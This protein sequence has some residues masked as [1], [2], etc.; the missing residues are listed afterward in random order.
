ME[1][2]KEQDKLHH[3]ALWEAEW[4]IWHV[5]KTANGGRWRALSLVP[6]TPLTFRTA[7]APVAHT[8][9]PCINHQVIWP[10]GDCSIKTSGQGAIHSKS[11]CTH[12]RA[13]QI[14]RSQILVRQIFSRLL[15]YHYKLTKICQKKKNQ[16]PLLKSFKWQ[17][18]QQSAPVI[19]ACSQIDDFIAS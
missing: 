12:K 3:G 11:M 5:I 1:W 6:R 13:R 8:G 17:C 16:C 18:C 2:E 10:Q 15:K 7:T 4:W 9:S 14:H 19:Q